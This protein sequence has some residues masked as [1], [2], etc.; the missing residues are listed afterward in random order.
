MADQCAPAVLKDN[1][2]YEIIYSV[3]ASST[4]AWRNRNDRK[5]TTTTFLGV[6]IAT[7]MRSIVKSCLECRI[8]KATLPEPPTRDHPRYRLAYDHNSFTFVGLDYFGPFSVTVGR[9][10]QK[11]YLA[12]FMCVTTRVV[13]LEIAAN[14]TADSDV[15]ALRRMIT[16]Q[17]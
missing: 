4:A 9:Q 5:R 17:A 14:L 12:L 8:K 11:G 10:H 13:H 6:E 3:A 2:S 15:L 7:T 16:C 1:H